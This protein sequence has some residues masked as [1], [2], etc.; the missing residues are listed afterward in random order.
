M[1][2]GEGR[3]TFKGGSSTL[4]QPECVFVEGRVDDPVGPE[5]L[6]VELLRQTGLKEGGGLSAQRGHFA[7]AGKGV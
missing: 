2:G 4:E 3:G 5:G 1:V 6:G 7:E